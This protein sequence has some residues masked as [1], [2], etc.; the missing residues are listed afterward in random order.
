[1]KKFDGKGDVA[2][3]NERGGPLKIKTSQTSRSSN[4]VERNADKHPFP[5][6]QKVW[7]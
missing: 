2:F 3:L 7:V 6:K 4:E 1:M 5:S